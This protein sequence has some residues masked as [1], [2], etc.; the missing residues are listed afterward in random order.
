MNAFIFTSIVKVSLIHWHLFLSVWKDIHD[1][2]D[3]FC[4]LLSYLVCVSASQV[5]WPTLC[6]LVFGL[7]WF[8]LSVSLNQL[9]CISN[10]RVGPNLHLVSLKTAHLSSNILQVQLNKNEIN[11]KDLYTY[12]SFP[13]V[14]WQQ[15]N[16]SNR[17]SFVAFKTFYYSHKTPFRALAVVVWDEITRSISFQRAVLI[18]ELKTAHLHSLQSP[19]MDLWVD[20]KQRAAPRWLS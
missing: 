3:P 4:N 2:K 15:Q 9:P 1:F 11:N 20:L 6:Q 16:K 7:L 13:Q 14:T 8:Y 10:L 18:I 5:C 12:L 17:T 19:L